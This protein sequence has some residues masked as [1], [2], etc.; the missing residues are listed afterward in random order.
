VCTVVL[1]GVYS[2]LSFFA[3]CASDRFFVSGFAAVF[4]C[5]LKRREKVQF[6]L[7]WCRIGWNG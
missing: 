4:S 5:V 2:P 6:V 1:G 7:D 3:G